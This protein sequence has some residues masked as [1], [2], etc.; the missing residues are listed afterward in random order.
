MKDYTLEDLNKQYKIDF[1]KIIKEIKN[2]NS[3][4]VL[5]QFVDGLKQ[6]ALAVV[7]Y[8]RKKTNSEFL[9]W[10]G[11]AFGA[12]DTPVGIEGLGIDLIIQIGHNAL[13]P[14]YLR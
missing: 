4:L 6:Y 14:S 13:Q 1:E 3:K 8:L 2:S 7:D 9:I 11:S 5:L 12:C 10:F